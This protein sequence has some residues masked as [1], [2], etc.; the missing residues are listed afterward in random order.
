MEQA[1]SLMAA[2]FPVADP[3]PRSVNGES[4]SLFGAQTI[5]RDPGCLIMLESHSVAELLRGIFVE[6]NE[7]A[8]RHGKVKVFGRAERIR[9]QRI[10]ETSDDNCKA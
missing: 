2:S 8:Q 5:R 1:H 7:V 6:F 3:L 10:L 9:S 4:S